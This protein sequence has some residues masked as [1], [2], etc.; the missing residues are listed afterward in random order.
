MRRIAIALVALSLTAVAV[1]GADLL[2]PPRP[3]AWTIVGAR[4]ADGSGRP[5]RPGRVLP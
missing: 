4:V 1:A 5:L 2:A 3:R